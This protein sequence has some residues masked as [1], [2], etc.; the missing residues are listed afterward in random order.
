FNLSSLSNPELVFWYHMWG[1][2]MGTMSIQVSTNG[3]TT[4]G[5][6]I[7][8]KTGDQGNS[9]QK[10]TVSLAAYAGQEIIFRVTGLTGPQ[11]TSDMALD[12]F[13]VGNSGFAKSAE[14]PQELPWM[15]ALDRSI[16]LFPNPS[17][18]LLNVRLSGFGD[19][20]SWKVVDM[21]GR[22]VL[23]STSPMQAVEQLELDVTRLSAGSYM[24]EVS[25][26]DARIAR[27]FVV[28]H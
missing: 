18:D 3:G 11:Y 1:P 25:D 12:D 4:F 14:A 2:G 27:R 17:S 21:Y 8:S 23:A 15:A 19:A 7:W 22:T 24:L 13:G 10:A 26:P 16:D 9:W 20:L 5:S 6:N 28:S